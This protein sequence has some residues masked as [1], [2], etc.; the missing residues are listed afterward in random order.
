MSIQKS[1]IINPCFP[2]RSPRPRQV[3]SQT[4]LIIEGPGGTLASPLDPNNPTLTCHAVGYSLFKYDAKCIFLEIYS[5]PLLF[6]TAELG[7]C[8]FRR[9]NRMDRDELVSVGI[10]E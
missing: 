8:S 10:K 3:Q 1:Q 9:G 4:I 6:H 5:C 7:F 2:H